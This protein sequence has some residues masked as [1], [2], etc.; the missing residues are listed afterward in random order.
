MSKNICKKFTRW[1][2]TNHWERVSEDYP[3]ATETISLIDEFISDVDDDLD[4]DRV[5]TCTQ[6]KGYVSQFDY[7]RPDIDLSGE[8]E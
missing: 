2:K 4:F 6:C 8:D 7:Y 1:L 5:A 3:G